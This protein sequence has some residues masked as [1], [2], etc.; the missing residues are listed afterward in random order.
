MCTY[1]FFI[2]THVLPLF[3]LGQ[4]FLWD[5]STTYFT[6]TV[7]KTFYFMCSDILV[8]VVGFEIFAIPYSGSWN[9][10]L[11]HRRY[12]V[13]RKSYKRWKKGIVC[14]K[15]QRGTFPNN[16]STLRYCQLQILRLSTQACIIYFF[17]SFK[18]PHTAGALIYSNEISWQWYFAPFSL[19]TAS[20]GCMSCALKVIKLIF[21]IKTHF[22][23][24]G[25]KESSI[26]RSTLQAG[27]SEQNVPEGEIA[28]LFFAWCFLQ[29]P[30]QQNLPLKLNWNRFLN[31]HFLLLTQN[32]T[33]Y[34]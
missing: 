7:P 8:G 32:L 10:H 5:W 12:I 34:I 27:L 23:W 19:S 2:A 16:K 21:W 30:E 18:G 3:P 24:R 17:Y 11:P 4:F 26:K 22:H 9:L 28:L 15:C 25:E 14:L 1:V 20:G 29:L 13:I 31:Y 33:Q 6:N